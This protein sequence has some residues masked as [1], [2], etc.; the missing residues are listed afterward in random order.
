MYTRF[1]IMNFP[2]KF[3]EDSEEFQVKI[4]YI[5][6]SLYVYIDDLQRAILKVKI[7]L[8]DCVGSDDAWVRYLMKISW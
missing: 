5:D 3:S 8:S 7:V 4:V 6:G 2:G 1:D